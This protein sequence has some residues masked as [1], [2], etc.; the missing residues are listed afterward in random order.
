MHFE[1]NLNATGSGLVSIT[2]GWLSGFDFGYR[3]RGRLV[4]KGGMTRGRI[5]VQRYDPAAVSIFGSVSQFDLVISG[6][7]FHGK[8]FFCGH[9]LGADH[10]RLR[11][12]LDPAQVMAAE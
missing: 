12:H 8:R 2:N 9:V 6:N 1:S 11:F 3:Y 5:R 4:A 10:L 7:A